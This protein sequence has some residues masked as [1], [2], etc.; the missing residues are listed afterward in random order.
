VK[1]DW[2]ENVEYEAPAKLPRE[3]I[4]AIESDALAVFAGLGCRDVARADFRVRDGVPYFIEINPLPGLSPDSGD[5]V[6][7]AYRMGLTYPQLVGMILDAA[8]K[9]LGLG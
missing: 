3:V 4:Q 8:V 5:I 6:F 2:Q 1:R 7:L 9:R